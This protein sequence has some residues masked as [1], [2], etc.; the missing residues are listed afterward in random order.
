MVKEKNIEV[1]S[2]RQEDKDGNSRSYSIKEIE[3]GF[4]VS[5]SETKKKKNGDTEYSNK[6]YFVKTNPLSKEAE[7]IYEIMENAVNAA[8]PLA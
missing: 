6:E 7:N 4:I 3:N 8:N 1:P 5:V 2:I